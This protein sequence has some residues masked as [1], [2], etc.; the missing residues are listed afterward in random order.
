MESGRVG[1]G[2]GEGEGGIVWRDRVRE[3]GLKLRII[4]LL[5]TGSGRI[6]YMDLIGYRGKVEALIPI[7]GFAFS[8]PVE[9]LYD[10]SEVH[11]LEP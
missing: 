6:W 1:G 10:N 7:L 3:M 5:M 2:S 8:F 9:L 11:I 4:I